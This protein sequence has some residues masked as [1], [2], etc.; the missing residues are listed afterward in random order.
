MH[1]RSKNLFAGTHNTKVDHTDVTNNNKT[2]KYIRLEYVCEVLPIVVATENHSD[3]ILA[4][5]MN[6]TLD[7]C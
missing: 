4:D 7:G 3:N 1:G 2:V 6:V 5:I